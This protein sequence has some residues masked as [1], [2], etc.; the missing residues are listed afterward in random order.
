ML[1]VAALLAVGCTSGATP[2]KNPAETTGTLEPIAV[3][4]GVLPA[5]DEL[6]LW[7]AEQNGYFTDEKLPKVEIVSFQSAQER[8]AAFAS[9]AIDA[10]MGDMV[11]AANLEAGGTPCSILTIMLGADQSQGRFGVVVPP[12]STVTTMTEL[13]G[14]PV[15]ASSATVQ[16]YVLDG[17]MTEAGV[18]DKV[19]IEEVKKVPVRYELLMQG[20]LKAA[21]LPDPFLALAEQ[22]GATVVGDDTKADQNLSQTTL[23]FSDDFLMQ[24]A[25]SIS[26]DAVLSAWDRAA[27]DINADP[28]AY[29]ALLVE[30][31]GLPDD[32]AKTYKVSTYPKHQLPD[33]DRVDAVLDW[34]REKGY[35]KSADVDYQSLT[36]ITPPKK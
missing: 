30:T 35:L 34:M 1:A 33:K 22:N 13:A 2:E 20:K 28:E 17:L 31:A 19:V 16:E 8:D 21:A 36:L 27:A 29:R 26:A 9:G 4:I 3:R 7:V 10:L 32:L 14:V 23:I 18:G 15:G 12:K 11:A 6:P 25:G 5:E 24:S